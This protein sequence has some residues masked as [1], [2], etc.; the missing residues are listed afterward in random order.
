MELTVSAG[1][2]P[3]PGY[4]F[5]RKLGQGG[6]G[7][8]W[9]VEAPGGVRVAIKVIRVDS[10]LS[11]SELRALE[12]IRNIRHPHRVHGGGGPGRRGTG[13]E[14]SATGRQSH[15]SVDSICRYWWQEARTLA[16]A[17]VGGLH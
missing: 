17:A 4:R 3:V 10:E 13:R 12:L 15:R 14:P 1:I 6:F 7:E 9:E 11:K 2:E 5:L 8:V 16:L